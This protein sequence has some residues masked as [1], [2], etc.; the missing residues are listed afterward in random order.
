MT[1]WLVNSNG[2]VL[3]NNVENELDQ[4]MQKLVHCIGDVGLGGEHLT[5]CILKHITANV[6][7]C[8][9]LDEFDKGGIVLVRCDALKFVTHI[10][11]PSQKSTYPANCACQ[12][13]Q[14][15]PRKV[16]FF[17]YSDARSEF[18]LIC[19][20]SSSTAHIVAHG[21]GK[22]ENAHCRCTLDWMY[23]HY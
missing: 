14:R 6:A 2:C 9:T 17:H 13:G 4:R 5:Q 12:A 22:R 21:A 7:I 8:I 18:R 11:C 10:S 19:R 15:A 1:I 20:E 16:H 23:C 3:L